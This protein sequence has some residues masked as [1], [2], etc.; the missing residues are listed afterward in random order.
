MSGPC[1]ALLCSDAMTAL[2]ADHSVQCRKLCAFSSHPS[3][4]PP[5]WVRVGTK[6]VFIFHAASNIFLLWLIPKLSFRSQ[7]RRL[8][9]TSSRKSSLTCHS[10]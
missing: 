7:L 4:R 1:M 6:A 9:V 3:N 8:H 10:S 5:H 2:L